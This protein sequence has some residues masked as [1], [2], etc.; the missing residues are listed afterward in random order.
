MRKVALV[1]LLRL[2]L[3][4]ALAASAALLVDYQHAGDPAFCGVGSGCLAVRL[5]PYSKLGGIPLPTLGLAAYL[6]LFILSLASWSKEVLRVAVILNGL[7]ALAACVL[8]YL[9]AFEIHAFC[10]WCVVVD[11]S[12]IFAFIVAL[13]LYVEVEAESQ[14]GKDVEAEM[15]A[16]FSRLPLSVAWVLA[17]AASIVAPFVWGQFPVIPP[18]PPELAALQ[19]PGKITIVSF[20]DFECPYCRALHPLIEDVIAAHPDRIALVRRMM[21]LSGHPGAMP[22]A[23]AYTCAPEAKRHQIV[24]ALYG[25]PEPRLTRDGTIDIA[26]ALG[27]DR[28]ELARCVDS[29]EARA[30]VEKDIKLFTDIQG[31]AL[32]LTY[33]G[34]RA[35]LGF[36]PDR[37][38][39]AADLALQGDRLSLPVSWM[40]AALGV[41]WAAAAAVTLRFAPRR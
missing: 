29:P 39:E 4:V 31:Q 25:A 2:A 1:I 10:K 32:P 11:A 5:S 14:A 3:L 38:R 37:V 35:I 22:G 24:D 13:L 18:L 41:I 36:G 15:R 19:V 6:G 17:G 34:P 21:P 20:T 7:A 30:Q 23:L 33:V 12:A 16:L 9:Q 26:A 28:E 40:F 8:I 27:I